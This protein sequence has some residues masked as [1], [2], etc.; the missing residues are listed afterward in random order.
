MSL[1]DRLSLMAAPVFAAMAVLTAF[2]PS[3]GA[4]LCAAA[5]GRWVLGDMAPMYLL[6][7]LFH[8]PPWLRLVAVRWRP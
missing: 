8:M 1:A 4:I 5:R 2:A 6:M 3:D 7:T